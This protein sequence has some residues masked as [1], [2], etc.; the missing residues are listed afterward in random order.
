M[1]RYLM[2]R[3]GQ[4]VAVVIGVMILTFILVHLEPG[5]TARA[6]LGLKATPAKVAIFNNTYGLNR[7]LPVQFWLYCDHVLHGNFG[8][9]YAAGQPVSTLIAQRLPRDAVLIGISTLLAL[10]IGVPMGLYQAIHH[11]TVRDDIVAGTWFT[12][13][14]APD[15][16]E[17]L[18]LIAIVSVHF[19]LLPASFPGGITSIGGL[20]T[21]PS[22]LVLPVVVLAINSVA[23]FSQYMRSSAIE[24]LAQDYMRTARAKGLSE[25]MILTRHL[26]RN[27][28]L[29]IITILGLSLP[30]IVAGAVIAEA[31]FNFPGMGLLFWQSALS[32]DFPVMLGATLIIGVATVVGNLAADIAYGVL[33]PRIR[34]AV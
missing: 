1:T 20:F 27:A 18:L 26:L 16:M 19:H 5:S 32:H 33:D 6:V 29:P 25:R 13:Y 34:H 17:A 23:G 7:P 28:V 3:I 31:I 30:N 22:A 11:G 10:I 21:D 2:Q 12:L 4:S 9:S 14:S 15:F 24:E 8:I